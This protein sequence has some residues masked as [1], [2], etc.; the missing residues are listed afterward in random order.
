MAAQFRVTGYLDVRKPGSCDFPRHAFG[1][2]F[3]RGILAE[4]DGGLRAAVGSGSPPLAGL[5]DDEPGSTGLTA[6]DDADH[7]ARIR[8]N[9]AVVE[10]ERPHERV[11]ARV[12]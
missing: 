12:K 4:R 7:R 8:F 6:D 9:A 11:E 10:W 2:H 1:E 5:A 3:P